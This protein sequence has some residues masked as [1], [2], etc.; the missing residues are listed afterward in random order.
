MKGFKQ[1]I[2]SIA[3]ILGHRDVPDTPYVLNDVKLEEFQIKMQDFIENYTYFNQ[4]KNV[5]KASEILSEMFI[6][7]LLTARRQG[8]KNEFEEITNLVCDDVI[9]GTDQDETGHKIPIVTQGNHRVINIDTNKCETFNTLIDK[10]IH[11]AMGGR[12]NNLTF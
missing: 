1:K 4:D 7:I 10:V 6:Y 12:N 5:V 11:E 2:E 8:I 9:D 3:S